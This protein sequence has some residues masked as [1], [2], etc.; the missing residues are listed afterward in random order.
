MCTTFGLAD[1][2]GVERGMGG[3]A[4]K[5]GPQMRHKYQKLSTDGLDCTARLR[6]SQG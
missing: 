3:N 1:S 5:E 2:E 6:D 4:G